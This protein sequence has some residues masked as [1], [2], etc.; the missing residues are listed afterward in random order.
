MYSN[1]AMVAKSNW[2]SELP[3]GDQGA[4]IRK[5]SVEIL[6]FIGYIQNS[7]AVEIIIERIVEEKQVKNNS[8]LRNYIQNMNSQL[9]QNY[10][11]DCEDAIN[12]QINMEL[13]ASY[14]YMSMVCKMSIDHF[15]C[16]C[17]CV[18]TSL[19]CRHSTSTGMMSL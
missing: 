19:Y 6:N 4:C 10:H 17:Y 1:C 7:C 11:K 5:F 3:Q 9:R 14:T 13:F 18:M 15:C 16:C 2:S 8:A 12:K